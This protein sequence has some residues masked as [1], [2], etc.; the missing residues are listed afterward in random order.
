MY[1]FHTKYKDHSSF[2]LSVISFFMIVNFDVDF[3]SPSCI[4]PGGV[5]KYRYSFGLQ[6]LLPSRSIFRP[7]FGARRRR[8]PRA[9]SNRRVGVGK[10]SVRRIFRHLQRDTGPRRWPSAC[11]EIPREQKKQ[12]KTAT[13]TDHRFRLPRS[14]VLHWLDLVQSRSQKVESG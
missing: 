1:G 5:W 11:S 12:K 13:P 10:V 3:I 14:R 7:L 4:M 9:G 8:T 2:Y 6:L